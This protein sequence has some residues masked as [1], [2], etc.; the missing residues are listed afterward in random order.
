MVGRRWAILTSLSLS[1]PSSWNWPEIPSRL[2]RFL[3]TVEEVIAD[4]YHLYW[5]LLS[6]WRNGIS[7]I[8]CLNTWFSMKK[9]TLRAIST[10]HRGSEKSAWLDNVRIFISTRLVEHILFFLLRLHNKVL[11]SMRTHWFHVV[12]GL[13][14]VLDVVKLYVQNMRL[15]NLRNFLAPVM[16]RT[17]FIS[18]RVLKLYFSSLSQV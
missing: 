9:L 15:F 16:P 5:K 14:H 18:S 3:S 10:A 7:N 17:V 1:F 4:W 13:L 8:V 11:F 2:F 12:I 6:G